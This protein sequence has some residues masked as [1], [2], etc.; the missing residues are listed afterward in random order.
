MKIDGVSF[1][2]KKKD[3]TFLVVQSCNFRFFSRS[4]SKIIL[5]LCKWI[6]AL[7]LYCPFNLPISNL[8]LLLQVKYINEILDLKLNS[9]RNIRTVIFRKIV[10]KVLALLW[11]FVLGENLFVFT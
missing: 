5:P 3:L 9:L 8:G 4:L 10:L 1:I 2:M 7:Y 6:F 11:N